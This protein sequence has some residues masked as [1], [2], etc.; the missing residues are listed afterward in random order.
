MVVNMIRY[1]PTIKTGLTNEQVKERI[2][3]NLLNYNDQPQT[4]TIGQ[5]IHDNF[6]TYFNFLNLALGLAVFIAS[7]LNGQ[8]LHGLKNCLF[9]GVIIINSI[10]SIIEEVV[11]KKIIDKLSVLNESTVLVIRD[12][13]QLKLKLD[14]LVLDD[15]IV[16][17]TGH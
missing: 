9:M 15:V 12:S 16:L 7:L 8:L 10:I 4:K 1:N 14:Q 2:N 6:F 13:E 17:E 3:N 11:S 5:I